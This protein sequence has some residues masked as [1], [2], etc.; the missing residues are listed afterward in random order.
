MRV[1][2]GLD[3]GGTKTAVT[4]AD[5]NGAVLH[6]FEAGP[7][8]L[9]GQPESSV[10]QALADICSQ[11]GQV[12]P[13]GI[14]GC[15]ALCVGAAGISNP[16]VSGLLTAGLRENGYAGE[17]V[18][19]GDHVTALSGALEGRP[20]AILIAGTGSIAY[21]RNGSG[22]THRAG[23]FGHLIDDG[24]S[25]YSL[26]RDLLSAVVR[27]ADGRE[28][29]TVLT[30]LAF[31]QLGISSIPELIGFVYDKDR[32]KKD[33]AAL[34]PLV[35]KACETG[36]LAA[37]RIVRDN[38]DALALTASAVVSRLGLKDGELALLGSVLTK[39]R[40]MRET[41]VERMGWRQPLL[42]CIEPRRDASYGA[43]LLALE[44]LHP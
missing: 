1:V 34:A 12:S 7:I 8:N 19:V 42:R 22:E 25:G 10:R 32:G 16:A 23:G 31:E 24:G 11:I 41:F 15:A 3:G 44:K 28:E 35:F 21:G 9:N 17:L 5:E 38:A 37:L 39:S 29:P 27:A 20:G 14:E 40:L 36:D 43:V 18:L 13:G 26:G 33:I 6:A 30:E 2:A 4:V